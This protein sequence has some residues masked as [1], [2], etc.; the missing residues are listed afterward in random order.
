MRIFSQRTPLKLASSTKYES[1][2][3]VNSYAT[4]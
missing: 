4:R 2:I 3:V 1:G